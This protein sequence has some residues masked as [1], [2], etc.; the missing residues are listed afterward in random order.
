MNETDSTQTESESATVAESA[1]TAPPTEQEIAVETTANIPAA[2]DLNELQALGPAEIE[3]LCRDFELRVHPGR[4][5]HQHILDLIR[6]ALGLG[7]PVT[8]EG[9][10]DQVADS[11]GVLR[12]PRL[13]FLPVPEDVGVPRALT[14]KFHFRPGQKING[15]LRL[16]RD[17]E[18]LLMLDEVTAIEGVPPEQWTEPTP[19]DNLTPLF[20][21]GRIM[22][23]NSKTNSISVRAV[24]L[25]TPLGRGQRGLIV[26]A[27]RVG[28]TILL[29]EIAKAIRVN[30]PEIVLI[31]L[32]V[33]ERP[34]EVTDL[35]REVDCDVYNSTFD[36]NSRRHVEVLG[37]P[38][39]RMIRISGVCSTS[40]STL[41]HSAPATSSLVVRAPARVRRSAARTD[42][43]S[44]EFSEHIG[45]PGKA[46][47]DC[48]TGWLGPLLGGT[49]I[50]VTSS[51][52]SNFSRSRRAAGAVYFAPA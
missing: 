11:F 10:F 5:R 34:E 50:A 3:K 47:S 49:S 46:A 7:I 14:Q 12:W 41:P 8:A 45:R 29:K 4:T 25:L 26:A 20:P 22:L 43:V 24:D 52:M 2:L 44:A 21:D 28:K 31:I 6:A 27:P 1:V 48:R 18:K 39:R 40:L 35:Q 51:S 17:R 9:F 33:D 13:N 23:E 32:L 36:E 42:Q 38:P 19:F 37:R 16:P 15:T 30:H